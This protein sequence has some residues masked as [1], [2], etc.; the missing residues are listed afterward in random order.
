MNVD[1]EIITIGDEIL[2]GQ[3]VNTNASHL[4]ERLTAAGI[5]IGWM[6][7]VG[8]NREQILHALKEAKSR[9]GAVI[10]TGG[11]GPTPD[12]LTKSCLVEFF[13]DRLVL[14]HDLLERVKRR[15]TDRGFEFPEA[16]RGQAEFPEA[17]TEISNPN[18][19]ATGIHYWRDGVEWFSLPGVPIEMK[20]LLES[21]VLPRLREAGFGKRI[22]VSILRTAGIGESH[23]MEKLSHLEEAS[24]LADVAF[25]PRYYGVDV[26][27]TARGENPEEIALKLKSAEDLLLP[28]LTPFVYGRDADT[29]PGVLGR[30]A[31]EKDIRLAVAES[32]TAGLIAKLITDVAG[33]SEYFDRGVITYSNEAKNELL[34]VPLELIETEGAVSAAVASAMA[35]GLLERGHADISAAVTGIAGPTGGTPEKPVG[36]VYIATAD[37]KRCRTEE[38]RFAGN[39][40]MIRNRA[41]MAVINLLYDHIKTLDL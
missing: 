37:R 5:S 2:T 40:E 9:A 11:L 31:K 34:G 22:R 10:I 4:G 15:F 39:R 21:Y 6:T 36:L 16:S 7:V 29:L 1:I 30:A 33:S 38:Y 17:A 23:L 19:T 26:K 12:D 25:L 27:L 32:C 41:A 14:K 20:E 3:V 28:D 8:D 24:Q 13:D 35:K 18:G